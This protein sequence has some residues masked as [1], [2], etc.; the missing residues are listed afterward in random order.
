MRQD[1]SESLVVVRSGTQECLKSECRRWQD[2]E[3]RDLDALLLP[4]EIK[5]ESK[6]TVGGIEA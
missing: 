4:L 5:E 6:S 2:Q 1:V 3:D